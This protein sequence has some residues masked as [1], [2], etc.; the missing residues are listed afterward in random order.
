M[1]SLI[2]LAILALL[3]PAGS[4]TLSGTVQ[5]DESRPV[6]GVLVVVSARDARPDE[7]PPSG[8][9]D[10]DGR[11]EIALQ[12]KGPFAVDAY[13]GGYGP[14]R[15]R[16]VDP[17]KPLRIVLKRGGASIEGLVRD[18]TSLEPIAGA[19]V[20]TRAVR[21]R[22]DEHPRWGLVEAV[23]DEA[24]A[25]RLTG[26][27]AGAHALS[28]SAP[29]YGRATSTNVRAGEKVELF[30]FPGA[31]IYGRVSD[32]EGKPVE[33]AVVSAE[34]PGPMIAAPPSSA[35]QIADAEGRFAFL[36]LEPGTYRL[37]ARH[38]DFAPAAAEA[39]LL[40]ERDAEVG[41]VLGTGA[42]I[43]GRLVSEEDEPVRG[44][45]SL[46]S[47]DGGSVGMLLR[48]RFS[49]EAD[50]DGRFSLG[51]VPAGE[52]ALRAEAQ[53]YGAK[54]IEIPVSGRSKEED[55]G[56][57]VLEKGLAIEGRVVGLDGAP[58]PEARVIGFKT[59]GGMMRFA[60]MEQNETTSD[61]EGRFVVAGL[62]EGVYN[63]FATAPGYGGAEPVP[64]EAGLKNLTLKLKPAGSIR[65]S[66]VDSDGRAVSSFLAMARS[67]EGRGWGG[68]SQVDEESGIFVLESVAEG[69]YVVEI[70]APDYVSEAVSA[71]R[72]T[73][74]SVT[75]VGAIRLRRGGRLAGTVV[76]GSGAPVA[77]ATVQARQAGQR[78]FRFLDTGSTSTDRNGGFQIGG[79]PDGKVDVLGTHPSYADGR[80]EGIQIDSNRAAPA[81]VQLI[82]ERGGALEGHVRSRD[83]TGIAGR[84]IQ[85][86][87]VLRGTPSR[88]WNWQT[89]QS[90]PDGAFRFDH[91][92]AGPA[93]VALMSTETPVNYAIQT[94]EVEI[95]EG[96]TAYVE[97]YS[98]RVLVQGQ[99]RRGGSALA[100]V[101]IELH[102]KDGGMGSSV[103]YGM[104]GM[105][106]PVSGPQYLMALSGE[107][108]YYELLVDKP[109]EYMVSANASGL[110]LPMKT[111]VIPAV[112]TIAIDLDFDATSVSGRVID[113][114][115]EAPV[116]GA[117]VYARPAD[118]RSRFEGAGLRVGSD[119]I[120]ELEL[121]P[122]DYVLVAQAEGYA[123][124]EE[125]A[126]VSANGAN[127]L[128]IALTAGFRITGRIVDA[129]GR[130]RGNLRVLAVLDLPDVSAR[131]SNASANMTVADG[132]FVLE[133]L[134][135]GRYNL[136]ADSGTEFAFARGVDA[137]TEDLEL[138]LAPG[139]AVDVTV[140]DTDGHPV[141]K[142]TLGITA[143]DGRKTRGL[144]A[145][146]GP[147]GRGRIAV[148]R[149]N[150]LVRAAL[151]EREATAT[152]G[153]SE[154]QTARIEI[155]L[156]A[157]TKH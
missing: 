89:T 41:I 53:G 124:R 13:V 36:G 150:V 133:G 107:D 54:T 73:G 61:A 85:V 37:F 40:E 42:R 78:S 43:T 126:R 114:D 92:E 93:E 83:G 103:R 125:R 115:T 149:G 141:P 84:V 77:G 74:G 16:D 44:K 76:D 45:V 121:E 79:L 63:V 112:D 34:W 12:G 70:V 19:V 110:G 28:A 20:E 98:R 148:P 142:A 23:T 48:R 69:E 122:G 5:D 105:G 56:E 91:I 65:G 8:K 139:G 27:G 87:P 64:A 96:E 106:P 129:N 97:L 6:E 10:R 50:D 9:S 3:Q 24:G 136:L 147:D 155:V 26:L 130:G 18:G 144:F 62:S 39:T 140:I 71:V 68:Q 132:S 38:P 137:G 80:V 145:M 21:G 156:P 101:E 120:F 17:A 127:D 117:Y 31:G 60:G 7:A 102:S 59:S 49:V 57:I 152:V 113:K 111:L 94:Q 138:A 55:L 128:T 118:P 157:E 100:G 47:L 22:I 75:E 67:P 134:A 46:R 131:T 119:G 81:E 29:G 86:V 90:L 116:A 151:E 33:G 109:G 66:V 146:T 32:S 4:A 15:A 153:V 154:N 143:V 35:E 14:F 104:S 25:F 123:T 135:K 99:V 95:V 52:H 1:P 30:L 72:V 11:F 51:A 82:L 108:G 88:P 2:A 58:V